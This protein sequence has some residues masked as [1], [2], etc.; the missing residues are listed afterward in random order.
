MDDSLVD[1]ILH[2]H[3]PTYFTRAYKV[4]K[5]KLC[6]HVQF[7]FDFSYIDSIVYLF[8]SLHIYIAF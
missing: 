6:Y 2:F 3:V 1:D 5:V 4:V 7:E 8:C